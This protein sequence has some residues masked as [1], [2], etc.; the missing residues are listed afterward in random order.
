MIRRVIGIQPLNVHARVMSRFSPMACTQVL[1]VL[2][3][4]GANLDRANEKGLTPLHVAAGNGNAQCCLFLA[5]QGA[6]LHAQVNHKPLIKPFSL[7][8][9]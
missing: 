5:Q 2:S 4:S 1:K 8:R 7:R 6:D 9:C 3:D